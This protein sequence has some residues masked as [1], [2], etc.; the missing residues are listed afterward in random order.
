MKT[1]ERVFVAAALMHRADPSRVSFRGRQLLDKV[2]EL[3]PTQR[4]TTINA[5][6]YLHSVANTKPNPGAHRVLYRNPDGTL[7][8]YR[9]GDDFHPDRRHGQTAPD[10]GVV[11]AEYRELV[12]WYWSEYARMQPQDAVE[13]PILALRGVGREVWK[14]LG[15]VRFVDS[16][17]NEQTGLPDFAEVW[18]RVHR[19]AGEAFRTSTALPFTYEINGEA[20]VRIQREGRPVNRALHRRQFE[21]A[22]ARA[23]LQKTSELQD[24][25][26]PSY[27][28]AILTDPR[29]TG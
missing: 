29:I 28:F 17:R 20:T 27:L 11:P 13:D 6:L 2:R 4:E 22:W 12:E 23:P 1:W 10:A 8:L 21:A 16:L 14:T 3:D 25:Q 19:S 18:K 9:K 15:G 7:R 26:G 24:L 5:H